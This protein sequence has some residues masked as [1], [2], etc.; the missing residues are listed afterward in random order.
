MKPARGFS[1]IEL[2]VAL[3]IGL[4]ISIAAIGFV[5]SLG[6]ANSDD[7][8]V[9][10][11]TQEL[12][13]LSEVI[14]REIRRARYVED[15]IG[16]V[17]QGAAAGGND[18][19]A[20]QNSGRC[21]NIEYDEPPPVGTLVQ[22][23]IYLNTVDGR[24]YTTANFTCT[25]GTAISSPEVAIEQLQFTLAGSFQVNQQIRGRLRTGADDIQ[26]VRREFNQT[27]YIRSGEVN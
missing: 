18:T 12:R 13:S 26:A 15:P 3:A 24:I 19:V 9:T 7:I 27:V 21:I 17:G 8:R 10:R 20:L 16:L 4:V 23:S 22:R 1:L 6:K 11:L 14:S 2:M 5:V 25:G